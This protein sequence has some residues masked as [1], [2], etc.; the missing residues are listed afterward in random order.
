MILSEKDREIVPYTDSDNKTTTESQYGDQ[1]KLK[2]FF[3]PD[4]KLE[5]LVV[6]FYLRDKN[7]VEV[8]G[9]NN[10]NEGIEISMLEPGR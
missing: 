3:E 6:A 5:H 7:R 10:V 1:L 2:I 9:S 4:E 8:I